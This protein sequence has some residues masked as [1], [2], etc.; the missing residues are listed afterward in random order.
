MT[1]LI[2]LITI[3]ILLYMVFT[4]KE[5]KT[6]NILALIGSI[7]TTIGCVVNVLSLH[8]ILLYGICAVIWGYISYSIYGRLKN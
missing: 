5:T 8:S 2:T 1:G 6:L 4:N 3:G 7:L